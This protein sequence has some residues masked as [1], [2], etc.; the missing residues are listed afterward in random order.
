MNYFLSDY[1]QIIGPLIP[2]EVISVINSRNLNINEW[3][4][5]DSSHVWKLLAPEVTKLAGIIIS[6]DIPEKPD[7]G[8]GEGDEQVPGSVKFP[9][10]QKEKYDRNG[11]FEDIAKIRGVLDV[12]W[13]KQRERI[14]SKIKNKKIKCDYV[15]SSKEAEQHIDQTSTEIIQYWR[16]TGVIVDWIKSITWGKDDELK[17]FYFE[18]KKQDPSE[19]EEEAAK[20]IEEYEL[21]IPGCYCFMKQDKYVYIGM[22]EDCLYKRLKFGH[23]GKRFWVDADSLRILVPRYAKQVKRL[24]R[25]L[26]LNYDPVEN[27]SPGHKCSAAD[28]VLEIIQGEVAE[29]ISD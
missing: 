25:L 6:T 3:Q 14:I 5:C 10:Y 11:G 8:P 1:N 21:K 4:I 15:L 24:E 13:A 19:R 9:H 27:D 17:D 20:K 16:K 26:I 7:D 2:E 12:L 28:D 29:L 22:T 23:K 18:F